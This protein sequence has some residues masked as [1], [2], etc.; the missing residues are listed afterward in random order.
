[1]IGLVLVSCGAE[2]SA[3][4]GA[5]VESTPAPSTEVSVAPEPLP[6]VV[7]SATSPTPSAGS[8]TVAPTQSLLFDFSRDGVDGWYVQNDTVMGGVSSSSVGVER[9]ELVFAGNLSLDNNGGFASM[10]GPI[11]EPGSA[12]TGDALAIDAVGDGRTYLVQILTSTDSY[13]ARYVPTVGSTTLPFSDFT[14]TGW[15]LD[16]APAVAPLEAE[17][18]G[19]IAIYV[20]DKQV[21]EFVLRVRSI[22]VVDS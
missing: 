19:Q 11:L 4:E 12:G 5:A 2:R 21:G 15:R 1:M 22:S 8:S 14:S 13:V 18:I 17:S 7:S 10:R 3:V 6:S 20:L 16:P 9:D